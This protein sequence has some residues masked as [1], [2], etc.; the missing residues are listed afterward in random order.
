MANTKVALVPAKTKIRTKRDNR[1]GKGILREA[2][3]RGDQ[4]RAVELRLQ[5]QIVIEGCISEV[6]SGILI[7]VASGST[8]QQ[9][10]DK[11]QKK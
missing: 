5:V 4:V 1:V 7:V 11:N 9:K 3:G 8:A 6:P 10:S 2:K